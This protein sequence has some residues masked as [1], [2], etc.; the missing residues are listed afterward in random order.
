[1]PS[2]EEVVHDSEGDLSEDERTV[3]KQ[4]MF[5]HKFNF[6]FEEPDQEFVSKTIWCVRVRARAH[7]CLL[8]CTKPFNITVFSFSIVP[9]R[10]VFLVLPHCSRAIK[11]MH[12][13][14]TVIMRC[15]LTLDLSDTERKCF[16]QTLHQLLVLWG[17]LND[18]M[19]CSDVQRPHIVLEIMYNELQHFLSQDALTL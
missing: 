2:Y 16:L 1:M 15:I 12:I 18:T 6:R 5:E 10:R 14:V 19:G 11:K 7:V 3:G 4:E 13:T 17:V 8:F 9:L